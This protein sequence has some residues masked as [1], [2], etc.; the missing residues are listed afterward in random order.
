MMEDTRD[1][2]DGMEYVLMDVIVALVGM[3]NLG[4]LGKV[5]EVSNH[6]HIV[7]GF[8]IHRCL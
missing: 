5:V 8:I 4:K 1:W 6:M 3:E 2:M 7:P